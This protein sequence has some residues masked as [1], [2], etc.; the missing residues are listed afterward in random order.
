MSLL[1]YVACFVV[2]RG[3]VML[4]LETLDISVS[5]FCAFTCI[6]MANICAC[7]GSVYD[8]V[9][10]GFSLKDTSWAISARVRVYKLH[11]LLITIDMIWTW[12]RFLMFYNGLFD[13]VVYAMYGVYSVHCVAVRGVF[14]LYES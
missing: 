9:F 1:V 10:G 3:W 6:A 2:L 7:V 4:L 11:I 8:R 13:Q 5:H 12:I 14:T